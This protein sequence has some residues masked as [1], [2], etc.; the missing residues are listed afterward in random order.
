MKLLV[1]GGTKNL[2]RHV[3]EAA[4]R[5]GHGVTLFNRGL[6]NPGLFPEVTHLAGDRTS[7]TL[8]PPETSARDS[9]AWIR[10]GNT[11]PPPPH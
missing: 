10:A 1:L 6:T 7:L 5:D 4:L 2:G 3:V 8:R 11:P 9:I